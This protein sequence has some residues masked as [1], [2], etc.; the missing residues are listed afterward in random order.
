ML[1]AAAKLIGAAL[2]VVS[3]LGVCFEARRADRERMA[4][5][6]GFLRLAVFMRSEIDCFLT[7]QGR[8]LEKC[9]AGLLSDCGWHEN[10]PPRDLSELLSVVGDRM[11][12]QAYGI[13]SSF[14][15]SLGRCFREEQ[16]RNC[17]G[18]IDAL[19]A[20]RGRLETELPKRRRASLSIVICAAAAAAL[21][22]F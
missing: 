3:C 9:G 21:I 2:G 11:E 13:L 10:V 22:L 15:A 7:P 8:I 17:D 5:L 18:C 1:L 12:P 16:L 19:T 6:D 4:L 20:L 14:A